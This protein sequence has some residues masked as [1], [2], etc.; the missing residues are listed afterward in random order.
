MNRGG[1]RPTGAD[2]DVNGKVTH[3]S[4]TVASRRRRL[5][6]E[7]QVSEQAPLFLLPEFVSP[8]PKTLGR[9]RILSR[10]PGQKAHIMPPSCLLDF[11]KPATIGVLQ[12]H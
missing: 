1:D 4:R 6:N 11:S 3:R 7:I 2:C 12:R 5:W 9:I 10:W 8:N